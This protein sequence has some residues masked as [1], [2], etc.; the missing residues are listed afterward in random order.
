MDPFLKS[1]PVIDVD[2]PQVRARARALVDRLA[3][4]QH[5]TVTEW[6]SHNR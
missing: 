6:I 4:D 1:T 5:V 2:H 3:Q